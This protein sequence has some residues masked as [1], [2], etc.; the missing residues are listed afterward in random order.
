MAND[1]LKRKRA[2]SEEFSASAGVQDQKLQVYPPEMLDCLQAVHNDTDTGKKP[3][4]TSPSYVYAL[5][6]DSTN[7]PRTSTELVSLHRTLQSANFG[8]LQEF[9]SLSGISVN[10]SINP[11]E[12][13]QEDRWRIGPKFVELKEKKANPA[14]HGFHYVEYGEIGWGLDKHGCISLTVNLSV[15]KDRYFYGA[16]IKDVWGGVY[17]EKTALLE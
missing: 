2:D 1:N 3:K 16:A 11:R 13:D 7:F 17:V 5:F 8:A 14:F 6:K 9:Q 12:L 10:G 15:D 4:A